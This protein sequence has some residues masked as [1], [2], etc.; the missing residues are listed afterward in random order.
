MSKIMN[1]DN[2]KIK[3]KIIHQKINFFKY[4]IIK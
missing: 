1:E 4:I 2:T 3:R